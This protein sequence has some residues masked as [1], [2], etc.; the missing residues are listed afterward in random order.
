VINDK[1]QGSVAGQLSCDGYILLKT[2][3]Y[4]SRRKNFS[5]R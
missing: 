4:V 3:H 5:N 1:S 2:F